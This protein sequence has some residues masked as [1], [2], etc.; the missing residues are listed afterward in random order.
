MAILRAPGSIVDGPNAG[1]DWLEFEGALQVPAGLCIAQGQ[2][3]KRNILA[4]QGP[5]YQYPQQSS[6]DRVVLPNSTSAGYVYGVYQG[7]QL[8]APAGGVLPIQPASFRRLG[9]G[10]VL[11]GAVSGG[12][13]V[14]IGSIVGCSA[15]LGASATNYAT[16]QTAT[17]GTLVGVVMAQPINTYL[18]GAVTATGS[19]TVQLPNTY[20]ITT[21]TG[22]LIDTAQSGVQE[23]VT[24]T[25]VVRGVPASG[26]VTIVVVSA[27]AGVTITITVNG[28]AFTYVTT[29]A[30]TTATNTAADIVAAINAS[31]L[32]QGP[33]AVIQYATN[34]AGVITLAVNPASGAIGTQGT[35][36]NA[37]TLTSSSSATGNFTAT[38]S[39]ATFAGGTN[40]TI[41]AVFA[42]THAAGAPVYGSN[43]TN[44]ASVIPVSSATTFYLTGL[45]T[46]DIGCLSM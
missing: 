26:T 11:C 42:N 27:A 13:A 28:T 45:V 41:T 40:S 1:T 19:Q 44:A 23:S 18:V 20:A 39:G 17:I 25:A 36:G 30:D 15:A 3:Y 43:T 16:V 8:V 9:V 35:A 2:V 37:I 22:L 33:N 14:T 29:A 10:Q 12:T 31:V 38:A 4:L 6:G 5:N 46:V 21:S 7:P 24:P 32:T 34:A